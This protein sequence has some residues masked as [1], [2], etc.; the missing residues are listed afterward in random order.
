MIQITFPVPQENIPVELERIRK[1]REARMAEIKILDAMR[2]AV[3]GSCSH[4]KR[5][6]KSYYDGSSDSICETCGSSGY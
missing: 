5:Y 3:Q 2:A 6:T 4:P 1:E